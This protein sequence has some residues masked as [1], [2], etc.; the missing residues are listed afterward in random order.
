MG[1]ITKEHLSEEQ[2]VILL[3]HFDQ[4]KKSLDRV[5]EREIN[6]Y[7]FIERKKF[8]KLKE[9]VLNFWE[10]LDKLN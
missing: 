4:Y 1:K 10:E 6:K 9:N 3:W 8:K 7:N 2:F 5:G